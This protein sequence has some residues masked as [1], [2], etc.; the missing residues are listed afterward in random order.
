[1]SDKW[2]EVERRYTCPVN[3]CT[4]PEEAAERAA[5]KAVR[6]TFA[7][8]GV[9]IDNPESVAAFNEDLRFNKTL[10]KLANKGLFTAL[11]TVVALMIT[12]VWMY[13]TRSH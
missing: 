8:L 10:R 7:I 12:S 4:K 6:R 13:W 3:A 9:N 2:P 1:M 11:G 5:D